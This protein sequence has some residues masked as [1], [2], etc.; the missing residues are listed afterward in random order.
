MHVPGSVHLCRND[1]GS[2]VQAWESGEQMEVQDSMLYALDGLCSTSSRATHRESAASL[3]EVC[4]THRGRLA[5]KCATAPSTHTLAETL[6]KSPLAILERRQHVKPV[7]LCC[8]GGVQKVQSLV[9]DWH[10]RGL[11]LL[12]V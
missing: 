12:V 11:A 9:S 7:S 6:L 10:G 4:A 3:A 8:Q 1:A 2:M 5:L